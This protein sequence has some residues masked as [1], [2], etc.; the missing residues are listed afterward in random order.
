MYR[1][2]GLRTFQVYVTPEAPKTYFAFRSRDL[3]TLLR[4]LRGRMRQNY[5][6]LLGKRTRIRVYNDGLTKVLYDSRKGGRES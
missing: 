3:Q 1:D 2:R 5:G 4:S 6:L